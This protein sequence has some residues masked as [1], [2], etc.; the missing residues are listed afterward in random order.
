M[1]DTLGKKS[2]EGEE[3]QKKLRRY[4]NRIEKEHQAKIS[5]LRRSYDEL[6]TLLKAQR[7]INSSLNPREVLEHSMQAVEEVMGVK[8]CVIFLIDKETGKLI[9][10]VGKGYQKETIKKRLEENVKESIYRVVRE[11]EDLIVSSKE[12]LAHLKAETSPRFQ[13]AVPIIFQN[14][15][16][17]AIY[18]ESERVNFFTSHHLKLLKDLA[19]QMGIAIHNACLCEETRKLA[20][21]DPLTKLCTRQQFDKI[22]KKEL[23]KVKRHRTD[24]SLVLVDV[25]NLKYINDRLGHNQGD[26]LLKGVAHL[27]KRNVRSTDTVAR[28]GGDEMAIVL[29]STNA[30]QTKALVGR[31]RKAAEEWNRQAQD[32]PLSMNLSIGWTPVN[33]KMDLSEAVARADEKMYQDKRRQTH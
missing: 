31:I 23:E 5:Q 33:G 20:T 10:K 21:V 12:D 22:L 30:G 19:S 17:G 29:P 6:K 4:F 2:K 16:I 25:N 27:L 14:Q 15:V 26:Y 32:S 11:K 7:L 28:Y 13:L 9:P 18:L 24:L 3:F 8:P 1:A